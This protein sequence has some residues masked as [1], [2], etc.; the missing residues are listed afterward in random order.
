MV[1]RM[2]E[3]GQPSKVG[4]LAPPAA[5]LGSSGGREKGRPGW[6]VWAGGWVESSSWRQRPELWAVPAGST[7]QEQGTRTGCAPVQ[8]QQYLQSLH[9]HR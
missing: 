1:N 8:G 2:K 6:R 4:P 3:P 9:D 5:A 7:S